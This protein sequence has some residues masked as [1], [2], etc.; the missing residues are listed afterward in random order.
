MAIASMQLMAAAGVVRFDCP[1]R[2]LAGVA[3]SLGLG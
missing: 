1:C 3:R 2:R